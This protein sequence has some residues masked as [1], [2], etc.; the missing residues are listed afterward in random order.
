MYLKGSFLLADI[1]DRCGRIGW[2]RKL[3][4]REFTNKSKGMRP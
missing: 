1:A 2:K 4:D 3:A